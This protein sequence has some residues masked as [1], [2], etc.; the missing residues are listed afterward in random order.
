ML[1]AGI[2]FLSQIFVYR[3]ISI[4]A[5]ITNPFHGTFSKQPEKII[6]ISLI[7]FLMQLNQDIFLN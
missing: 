2:Y 3:A 6:L 5:I 4:S 1:A 7:W